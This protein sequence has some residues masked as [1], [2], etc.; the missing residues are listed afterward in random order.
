MNVTRQAGVLDWDGA[1]ERLGG[2]EET[3]RAVAKVFL[4]QLPVMTGDVR[5]ALD[6]G[7]PEAL[8][9]AAHTLKGSAGSL[10]ADPV[11]DLAFELEQCGARGDLGRAE[12]IRAR[13]EPLARILESELEERLGEDAG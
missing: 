10:G 2:S 7:D 12:G 5:S 6:A 8:Q 9:D 13:L 11:A 1:V 3:L 4:E